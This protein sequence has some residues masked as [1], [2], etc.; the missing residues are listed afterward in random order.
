MRWY[1]GFLAD[2]ESSISKERQ[3]TVNVSGNPLCVKP[4]GDG[5]RCKELAA[6]LEHWEGKSSALKL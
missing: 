4:K 2:E 5:G 6:R 3:Y 1:R